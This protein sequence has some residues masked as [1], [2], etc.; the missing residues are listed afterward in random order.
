M[1]LP[2]PLNNG[3]FLL[4]QNIKSLQQP[5]LFHKHRG[6]SNTMKF[7]VMILTRKLS[8]EQNGKLEICV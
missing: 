5:V 3:L 6:Q 1:G 7:S 8:K 4:G 2:F